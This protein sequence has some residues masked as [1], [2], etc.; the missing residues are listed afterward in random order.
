MKQTYSDQ[1]TDILIT[2][3][4]KTGVLISSHA[5]VSYEH[6]PRKQGCN[7]GASGHNSPGAESLR[8]RREVPTILQVSSLV[9]YICFRKNSGSNM[10]APNLLLAPGVI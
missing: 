4:E 7:E 6:T 2:V 5:A 9:Q 8:G 1:L 3:T 10:G